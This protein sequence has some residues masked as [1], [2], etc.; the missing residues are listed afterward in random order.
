MSHLGTKGL[1]HPSRTH[2]VGKSM[3]GMDAMKAHG[4]ITGNVNPHGNIVLLAR[5]RIRIGELTQDIL[6]D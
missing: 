6:P 2:H 1:D 5:R 4:Q 3:K